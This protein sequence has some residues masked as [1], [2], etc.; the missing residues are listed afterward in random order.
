MK[1]ILFFLTISLFF[2][3]TSFSDTNKLSDVFIGCDNEI[4]QNY[5]QDIDK[6][7]I[8]KIEIDINNYRKWTIN[9][10]KIITSNS[11]FIADEYKKRFKATISVTY[12]NNTK[13]IFE[14][15]VRHSG[16]AKDHIALH[17][18]YILQ[19]LDVHLNN[20]NIRGVTK[21]K[22][23]RPNTR[24]VLED[25]IIQT[26]LLRNLDYLAPR[27]IK[28]DA[29]INQAESVMLFQEKAAKELLE[30][31]K[32]REGP[33]LEGDQR[34]FFRLV[35]NIPSNQLSN[36]SVGTPFLRSKSVKAMLTKQTNSNIIERNKY[37]KQMSYNALTNLNL[38]YLYFA[39]RFQDEKNNFLFF[40]YDLDNSL[41]GFFDP[42]HILK[43]DI[44]NLLLQAT[45]SHHGLGPDTRKFY[46]NSIENYYEPINYD[47]NPYIE[48]EAPTTTTEIYRFPISSQFENAFT[49]LEKKLKKLNLDIFHKK[50]NRAGLNLT[51]KDLEAKINKILKN[52]SVIKNNYLTTNE[53]ELIEHNKFKPIDNIFARFNETLSEIDPSV[54]LVKHSKETGKLQR[55]RLY[56]K[57]CDSFAFSTE[58]I[59]DLLEGE[60]ILKGEE[61]QYIGKNTE[62]INFIE[63]NPNTEL[64]FQNTRMFYSSG[65]EVKFDLEKNVLDINQS[66]PGARIFILGGEL[67]DITINFN[68]YKKEFKNLPNF[69][70]DDRGLTG[71]LSLININLKNVFIN[72]NRSSCEDSVNLIN[73]TGNIKKI[74]IQ[75]SYMDG[76]DVDFSELEINQANITD[77][78]NDCLD[79]S[80][81][82]YKLGKINL[83]NCGD[84]GLSVGEKSFVQIDDIKVKNS[85]VGVASK[86]SSIT[87]LNNA[88][89]ENLT[90]C[91]TAYNKKQEFNGGFLKIKKADCKNYN[92]KIKTDNYSKIVIENEI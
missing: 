71:C 14:G 82:K 39:N 61:Y 64:K 54:Y 60:L 67:K 85:I 81:G 88:F 23:F 66:I 72:S 28:V 10:I 16:D 21:F 36:W 32:R 58:N 63:A 57:N 78:K 44:Y 27:S 65:I 52:L 76:L 53:K 6:L 30:Y 45:N 79:L 24:G 33:I 87:K 8:K 15:R 84:K 17:G 50:I 46:W 91:V 3:N 13:C 80:F 48:G 37:Y 12:E 49:E 4:N 22:L 7:G 5:F 38:I 86:D 19:S 34:F 70:I 92:E 73:A 26:E 9:S 90:I 51:K 1:K 41:L 77:S 11:R 18:N 59:T 47:S 89:L 2:C 74:N 31:N 62:S 42:N 68:G 40:D 69:P 20:G 55:C 83:S 56:L 29:R 75:K 35:E 25:V 43:L